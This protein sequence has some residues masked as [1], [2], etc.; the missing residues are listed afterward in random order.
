MITICPILFFAS[1]GLV[2]RPCTMVACHNPIAQ[3]DPWRYTSNPLFVPNTFQIHTYIHHRPL[4]QPTTRTSPSNLHQAMYPILLLICL[5]GMVQAK[6]TRPNI[7]HIL[8]VSKSDQP[9]RTI[10][11]SERSTKVL[12]LDNDD[13]HTTEHQIHHM[14]IDDNRGPQGLNKIRNKKEH[15]I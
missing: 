10:I 8:V 15:R 14:E 7:I 9:K 13:D 12:N 6:P 5:L 3:S 4:S 11:T 2:N 1:T